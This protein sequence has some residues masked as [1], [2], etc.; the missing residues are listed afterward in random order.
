MTELQQWRAV[1]AVEFER[2]RK[3][4]PYRD[5]TVVEAITAEMTG[6]GHQLFQ[7]YRAA[8]DDAEHVAELVKFFDFP[9][10]SDVLDIGCG[11]GAMATLVMQCRP[12]L[13]LTLQNVSVHQLAQ[14]PD[15]FTL[16]QSDMHSIP[17]PD[18]SFDGAMVCYSLGHSHLER[19][20][21][22]IAR[23]VKPGG[24]VAFYDVFTTAYSPNMTTQLG[25]VA[26]APFRLVDEMALVGFELSDRQEDFYL[27]PGIADEMP[28]ETLEHVVPQALRFV[29]GEA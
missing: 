16:I 2:A 23:I 9:V 18:E 1:E 21:R 7:L 14:C 27:M 28:V 13:F 11:I 8:D 26:Y 19:F 5:D 15:G 22:E 6:K 17:V 24:V 29:K 12:D 20:V 10:F 3:I 25:Y 4:A